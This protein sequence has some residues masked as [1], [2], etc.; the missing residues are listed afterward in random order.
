MDLPTLTD[1]VVDSHRDALEAAWV[2]ELC[3]TAAG[4]R[5]IEIRRALGVKRW[6]AWLNDECPIPKG[7]VGPNNIDESREQEADSMTPVAF[8]P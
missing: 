7:T 8:C 2:S 5:V 4:Q 1:D 6:H 3:A